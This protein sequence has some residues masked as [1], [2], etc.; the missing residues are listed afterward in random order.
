MRYLQYVRSS[1]QI[2]KPDV[3]V[4]Q[5]CDKNDGEIQNKIHINVGKC[6]DYYDLLWEI[7]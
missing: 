4:I 1:A 5:K 7:Y 6:Y 3:N 2:V